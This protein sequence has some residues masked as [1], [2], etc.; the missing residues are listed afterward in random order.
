MDARRW[1]YAGN[2]N[3]LFSI[4]C[5]HEKKDIRI[6]ELLASFAC[7]E[8]DEEYK[9]FCLIAPDIAPRE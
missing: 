1:I 3:A 5:A 7:E 2:D 4:R 9:T 6:V 8:N